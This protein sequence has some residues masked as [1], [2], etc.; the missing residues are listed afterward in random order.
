MG[1]AGLAAAAFFMLPQASV[2]EQPLI[3]IA[4]PGGTAL[5]VMTRE[6]TRREWR[7][8]A[9]AGACED[10][11][12]EIADS[13]PDKPMTDVNRFDIDSFISWRNRLAGHRYRLP[14]ATEWKAIASELP[15][16]PFAKLFDDPRLAWAADYGAM[17]K[18]SGVVR[19]SGAFGAL[20]NG[21]SDLG[22]NVWEWTATCAS[23]DAGPDRCP[24]FMVEGTHETKLS[25]FVRDPA[26]GGC[27]AGAPPANVGFRLVADE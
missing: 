26:S 3:S 17:P 2:P 21:I 12:G 19:P 20:P 27:A 22:G 11:T 5:H 15:Q 9:V 13:E 23:K 14:T 18:I 7:S 1:L 6:V 16:A 24:A 10:L 8:C 4:L 25:V